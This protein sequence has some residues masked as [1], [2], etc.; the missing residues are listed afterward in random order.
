MLIHTS[1]FA[2]LRICRQI[3]YQSQSQLS[4]YLAGDTQYTKHLHL[5]IIFYMITSA[6]A[7]KIIM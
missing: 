1:Y 5:H 2:Q 6:T 4:K 3:L 7:T